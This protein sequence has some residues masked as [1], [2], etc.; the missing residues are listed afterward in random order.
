MPG[1]LVYFPIGARAEAIRSMLAHAKFEYTDKKIQL[2]DW[3]TY[4]ASTPMGGLP[5]WEEDGHV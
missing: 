5:I 2:A 3:P 1:T 4:K